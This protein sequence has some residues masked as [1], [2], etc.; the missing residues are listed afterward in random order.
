MG[1]RVLFLTY[2]KRYNPKIE[3]SEASPFA[4]LI[5]FFAS[6]IVHYYEL[7]FYILDICDYRHLKSIESDPCFSQNA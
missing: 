5:K 6:N 1:Y 3:I 4:F 7:N 2:D